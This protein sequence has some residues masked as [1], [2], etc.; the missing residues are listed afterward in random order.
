MRVSYPQ[1]LRLKAIQNEVIKMDKMIRSMVARYDLEE[2]ETNQ[3]WVELLELYETM[4]KILPADYLASF[5]YID[6]VVKKTSNIIYVN[7]LIDGIY[8]KI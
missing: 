7:D 2:L 5:D 3:Y 4:K 8:N 6:P 1:Y